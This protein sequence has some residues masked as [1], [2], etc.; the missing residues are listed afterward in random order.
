[1]DTIKIDSLDVD[2][3]TYCVSYP[4][5]DPLLSASLARFG[6][7]TPITV[8]GGEP[9]VIVTGFKRVEAAKRLGVTEV[10]CLLLNIDA[11]KALLTAI[12]DNLGRPLNTIEKINC[13]QRM[14]ALEF[15]AEE[16]YEV[17]QMVGLPV[18]D[19]TLKTAV[20][21]AV[22]DEA[23]RV[24]IV[25]HNL[26]ISVVEQLLWFD[27][28]EIGHIVALT[29]P[30][31]VTVGSLREALQ[32]LTLLKVRRDRIDFE[33]LE[34]GLDDMAALRQRVKRLTHPM[35]SDL[36]ERLAGIERSIALPPN[37][38]IKTDPVFEKEWIDI[39][40]RARNQDEVDKALSKLEE[41][42]EKGFFRSVF[43]LTHGLPNRN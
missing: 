21:A 11:K 27:S 17:A 25:R 8:L 26:P 23:V 14:L 19:R 5:E 12:N 18:R 41:M 35:L 30:L 3:R 42:R 4:L 32:L 29:D 6:I 1:M 20:S 24:F 40:V 34:E 33:Q 43:E 7:L 39:C 2:D 37:V 28:G 22:L 15:P 13:V 9:P 38:R 16:I 31:N 10:P 36:E